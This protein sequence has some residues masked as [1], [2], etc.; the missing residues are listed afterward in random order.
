MKRG[1]AHGDE[2]GAAEGSFEFEDAGAEAGAIVTWILPSP[3][4][5]TRMME[6]FGMN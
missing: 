2:G 5:V 1:M 3:Y 4:P 6:P